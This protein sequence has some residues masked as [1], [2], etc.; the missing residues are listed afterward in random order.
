MKN[1]KKTAP[2]SI[3][4]RKGKAEGSYEPTAEQIHSIL[5][6]PA[7]PERTKDKLT[8]LISDLYAVSNAFTEVTPATLAEDFRD[9]AVAHFVTPNDKTRK[10]Y[11]Q[12]VALAER[13]EPK[14]ARLIRRLFE[15]LQDPKTD[16]K[17]VGTLLE[18]VIDMSN[19]MRI[20]ESHPEIFETFARVLIREA[21]K[22]AAV[23]VGRGEKARQEWLERT[24][25]KGRRA[26]SFRPWMMA[27]YL[28]ALEEIAGK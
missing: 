27:E 9:G 10:L 23:K 12:I 1:T 5:L 7:T 17:K 2:K 14:D 16:G 25:K 8:D 20:H 22:A 4:A 28:R 19:E 18:T 6:D 11:T 15:M 3:S 13:H 24:E 26:L 21:R